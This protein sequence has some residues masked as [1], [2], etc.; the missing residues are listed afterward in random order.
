M[1]VR[2]ASGAPDAGSS[3]S[4]AVGAPVNTPSRA[5]DGAAHPPSC[6]RSSLSRR[7]RLLSQSAGVTAETADPQAAGTVLGVVH[8]G[9]PSNHAARHRVIPGALPSG[10]G[11]RGGAGRCVPSHPRGGRASPPHHDRQPWCDAGPGAPGP[12]RT[13][14]MDGGIRRFGDARPTARWCN[15]STPALWR[16]VRVRIPR[17]A[18]MPI[19]SALRRS[20]K[21]REVPASD[22]GNL[23]ALFL[24]L[25]R[26]RIDAPESGRIPG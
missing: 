10:T 7:V 21:G 4:H 11:D 15:G 18:P 8:D 2:R 22:D 23:T 17:R 14:R 3:S 9:R 19:R 1:G 12:P 13:I 20:H 5:R 25:P 24:P 26:G 6:G 16:E